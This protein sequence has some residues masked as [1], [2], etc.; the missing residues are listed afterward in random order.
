M[1]EEG[2]MFRPCLDPHMLEEK[3]AKGENYMFVFIKGFPCK[4]KKKEKWILNPMK[5]IKTSY[6]TKDK[7]HESDKS[8]CKE[9]VGGHFLTNQAKF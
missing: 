2:G 8:I 9:I 6:F 7:S 4:R 3:I 1:M 5:M